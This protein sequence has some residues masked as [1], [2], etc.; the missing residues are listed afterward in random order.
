MQSKVVKGYTLQFKHHTL[1]K[2][3]KLII[4]G[5]CEIIG[6]YTTDLETYEEVQYNV[7]YGMVNT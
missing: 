2:Y 5:Y 4:N 7:E 1:I 3:P 6:C